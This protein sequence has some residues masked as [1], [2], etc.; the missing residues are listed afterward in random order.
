MS[1]VAEVIG[2]GRPQKYPLTK[3]QINSINKRIEKGES[4]AVI[5]EALGTHPFAV[6][7]IRRG[8]TK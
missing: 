6:L 2:R 7:R 3:V 4:N 8:G 1:K 5:A